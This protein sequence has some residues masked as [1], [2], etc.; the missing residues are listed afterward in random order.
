LNEGF[1]LLRSLAY[2]AHVS[3]EVIP[4]SDAD[5]IVAILFS[6]DPHIPGTAR[7]AVVGESNIPLE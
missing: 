7:L 2:A 4:E 3:T 5:D 6:A 1:S